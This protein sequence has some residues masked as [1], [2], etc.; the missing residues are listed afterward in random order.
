MRARSPA[1]PVALGTGLFPISRRELVAFA[2]AVVVLLGPWPGVGQVFT[3]LFAGYANAV[4]AVF[5]LGGA[6]PPRF[7]PPTPAERAD[8]AIGPWSVTLSPGGGGETVVPLETRVLGYTPL[9]LLL[10]LV[11]A[12]RVP[13]RRKLLV[14]AIGGAALLARLAIGIALPVARL[15]GSLGAGSALAPAAEVV[16]WAFIAT[17]AISY[18]APLVSWGVGLALTTPAARLRGSRRRARS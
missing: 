9:A 1:L 10:A 4:V 5:D 6:A 16:W 15:L 14:L 11:L 7:A 12:T 13:P 3:V 17:P 18:A 8:P 2:L